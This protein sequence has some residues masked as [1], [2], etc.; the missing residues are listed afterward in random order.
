GELSGLAVLITSRPPVKLCKVLAAYRA[1]DA[2]GSIR[3]IRAIG[4]Q[5]SVISVQLFANTVTYEE[6]ND[7]TN[8]QFPML[9]SHPMR[10]GNW[11][12][13]IG[14]IPGRIHGIGEFKS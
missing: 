3:V 12:L 8:A 7:L 11:E 10:I 9:N 14:Q 1:N 13:S 4:G 5:V 2:K 6:T